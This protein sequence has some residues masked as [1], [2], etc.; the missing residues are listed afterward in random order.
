M[1][2]SRGLFV[3]VVS[4]AVSLFSLPLCLADT[5]RQWSDATGKFRVTA[6]LLE[7]K[8]GVAFLQTVDG[9]TLKVPVDRLS[10]ADQDFLDSSSNPFELVEDGAAMR[11]AADSGRSGAS[12]P[13]SSALPGFDWS[14][15]TTIDWRSANSMQ[16][17]TADQWQPP[18]SFDPTL[19]FAPQRAMLSKKG[20]FHERPHAVQINPLRGRAV[21]GFS[22][23]FGVP[24]S[25][26]RVSLVDLTSGRSVD[27]VSVEAHMRP[28]ALLNDGQTVLMVGASDERGGLERPYELQ[29]WRIDNTTVARSPSWIP[30]QNAT[31]E[32]SFGRRE[33]THAAVSSAVP[34]TGPHVMLLSDKGHLGVVDIAAR[35]PVWH[36][37]LGRDFAVDVTADRSLMAIAQG[38]S[39]MIVRSAT[40]EVLSQTMLPGKPHTAWPRIRWSPSGKHLAMA[41]VSSLRVLDVQSGEWVHEEERPGAPAAAQGLDFPHEEFLL[42]N[43]TNLVHLPTK[44]Q[45]C[46][47][48]NVHWIGTVGGTTFV[49]VQDGG[50]GSLGPQ[51]IPHPKAAQLLQAAQQDPKTFLLGPGSRVAIDVSGVPSQYQAETRSGLEEVVKRA[52]FQVAPSAPVSVVAKVEGPTQEAVQYIARGAYVVN[53]YVSKV[54]LVWEGRELWTTSSTNVPGVLTTERGETIQQRLDKLGQAPSLHVFRNAQ[55]PRFLQRPRDGGTAQ[56]STA[57][58]LSRF[59]PQGLQDL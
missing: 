57:L 54:T 17:A 13:A 21:V 19:P 16:A 59:T 48:Q 18:P 37:E 55:L 53:K 58:M 10:Q 23:T 30:F 12:G 47:Y 24:K 32:R 9:R 26:S 34:L 38:A 51:A 49:L 4:I 35:T 56:R 6:R 20:A 15:P 7:V 5:D 8:D 28:L 14:R 44:I 3:A 31:E 40:G 52:G 42:L 45:V 43:N 25:T 39:I 33:T 11:P 22:L 1:L 50:G 2:F 41:H 27:S 29:L 46:D 36:V